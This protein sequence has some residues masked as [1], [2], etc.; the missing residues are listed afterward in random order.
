MKNKLSEKEIRQYRSRG[1]N[2]KFLDMEGFLFKYSMESFPLFAISSSPS[3][4][5]IANQYCQN[6]MRIHNVQPTTVVESRTTQA[7]QP[8]RLSTQFS[9]ATVMAFKVNDTPPS[10]V[11]LLFQKLESMSAERK[12]RHFP[13]SAFDPICVLS[14][15]Q[16][17][18]DSSNR[19]DEDKLRS[20]L[21]T[22]FD[23]MSLQRFLVYLGHAPESLPQTYDD[24][25]N[26]VVKYLLSP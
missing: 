7:T 16:A 22:N 6:Q 9:S 8:P 14:V 19:T 20:S 15:V 11:N 23:R 26:I 5:K 24:K 12:C 25:L 3:Q 17:A 2:V 1:F 13:V 18:Q 21:A 4:V 10:D